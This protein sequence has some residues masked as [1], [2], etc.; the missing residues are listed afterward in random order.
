[1]VWAP[2]L[3]VAVLA[4]GWTVFWFHAASVARTTLA[5]WQAREQQ[6]GRN[7]RCGSQ[8]VGG[9]PFRIEVRCIDAAADL[10]NAS[11]PLQLQ[12]GEL[13][14]VSQVY[15]PTLLIAEFGA[16]LRVTESG[17]P[18]TL[19]AEWT[20]AQASLR[21]LPQAPERVSTS[22]DN[23]RLSRSDIAGTVLLGARHLE[24]HARLDPASKPDH[25][26]IDIAAKVDQATASAAP[27]LETPV[28]GQIAAVLEGLTDLEPKPVP[29]LLRE[30]Q[31]RGG[32]LQI[33][34]AR[35]AYAGMLATASGSLGLT[36]QGRLDGVVDVTVAGLDPNVVERL[37][38]SLKGG[39]ASL[40]GTRL[41]ALLGK[42]T[43]LEGRPAVTMPLRLTDGAATLGPLPLGRLEALY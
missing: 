36:P 14:A 6:S 34:N 26:V 9:Y 30:L 39:N 29:Q 16:P 11:P 7:F 42:P 5:E 20:L 25:P 38:P 32:R 2:T 43:Q 28:D 3:L 40:L 18:I 23:F 37:V 22:I 19:V 27:S 31:E 21:G 10:Q 35:V 17:S 4:A 12:V 1:M 13:L 15:Q 41:L 24:L 33:V 8:S